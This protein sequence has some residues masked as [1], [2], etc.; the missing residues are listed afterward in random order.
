MKEITSGNHR[1][2]YEKDTLAY[3]IDNLNEFALNLLYTPD[4]NY[5]VYGMDPFEVLKAKPQVFYVESTLVESLVDSIVED[6]AYEFYQEAYEKKENQE[7]QEPQI[8]EEIPK[9]RK[10]ANRGDDVSILD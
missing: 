8:V 3:Q 10:K 4:R 5:L 9:D 6:L 2:F 7:Y 1:H